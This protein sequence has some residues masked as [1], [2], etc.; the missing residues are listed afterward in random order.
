M[1]ENADLRRDLHRAQRTSLRLLDAQKEST[2][3]IREL[4]DNNYGLEEEVA[5]MRAQL[6][7]V[8]GTIINKIQDKVDAATFAGSTVRALRQQITDQTETIENLKIQKRKAVTELAQLQLQRKKKKTSSSNKAKS[9]KGKSGNHSA[10][11][12]ANT[13]FSPSLI[14]A[15]GQAQSLIPSAQDLAEKYLVEDVIRDRVIRDVHLTSG[16]EAQ[17]QKALLKTSAGRNLRGFIDRGKTGLYYCFHE[18]CEKGPDASVELHL[19]DSRCQLGGDKCSFLM[20]V[21]GI[22][23]HRKV[24]IYNAAVGTAA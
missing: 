17:L 12:D 11:S 22:G 1:A 2:E 10:P 19:A 8:T 24:Q 4:Q 14:T 13:A 20:K 3:R 6:A 16:V 5:N 18:V 7:F 15:P 9:E 23:S 21:V